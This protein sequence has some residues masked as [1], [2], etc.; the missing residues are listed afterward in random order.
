MTMKRANMHSGVWLRKHPFQPC[1]S[2]ADSIFIDWLFTYNL[3]LWNKNI[4]EYPR[5]PPEIPNT[6]LFP[7][8]NCRRSGRHRGFRNTRD[9][10]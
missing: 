5:V 8:A 9:P 6:R 7:P 10:P 3:P 1:C 4:P 2:Y